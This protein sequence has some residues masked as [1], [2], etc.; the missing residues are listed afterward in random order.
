MTKYWAVV[1]LCAL[2]IGCGSSDDESNQPSGPSPFIEGFNPPAPSDGEIQIVTPVDRTVKPGDDKTFCTYLDYPVTEDLDVTGFRIYQSET[3]HHATLYMA[4]EAKP[5]GTAECAED[6][7]FNV[8]FLA[9]GGTDAPEIIVP[10]GLAFRLP[11]GKQ[12]MIQTHWI[13]TGSEEL[14]VQTA[15]NLTV[16]TPSPDRQLSD[17]FNVVT[18]DIQVPPNSIADVTASC[19]MKEDMTAW[20]FSGHAHEYTTHLTVDRSAAGGSPERLYEHDWKPE[21]T[22][23]SPL[24]KFTTEAPLRFKTGDTV[25]V[26]CTVNNTL[27]TPI[28]F[29]TEMCLAFGFYYPGHGEFDCVNGIWLQ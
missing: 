6:D 2:A 21:Y 28:E 16:T 26:T 3:G 10:E 27:A 1:P 19:V 24:Q 17:L 18:T 22:T 23:N 15:A 13:N 20:L 7:M 9:G 14:E 12:L 11:A 4:R 29:P 8:S 25:T 5:P